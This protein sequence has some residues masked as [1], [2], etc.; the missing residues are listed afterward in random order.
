MKAPLAAIKGAAELLE[1]SLP[2]SHRQR[3]IGNIGTQTERM[4][5]LIDRLLELA[6][7]E[8]RN[9][10]DRAESIALGPLVA[11]AAANLQPTAEA[12]GVNI[13]VSAT[14][15]PLTVL[16]D[17]FLLTKVLTNILKNDIEYSPAGSTVIVET[18][19]EAGQSVIH[20]TDQGPG[21][22]DYAI[23]RLTERFYALAKPDGQKGS[24]LGLSFVKEIANL[25]G[26]ALDIRNAPGGGLVVSLRW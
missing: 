25:H 23:N 17:S 12:Q 16:S 1:R 9:Q 13:R 22:P 8:H 24:G 2:E 26:V 18:A 3:F 7:L 10:L 11:E 15:Q 19:S 4:Q 21:T 6:A 20:V 14:S 5:G